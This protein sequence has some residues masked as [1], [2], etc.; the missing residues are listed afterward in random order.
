MQA[1]DSER[2]VPNRYS[3]HGGSLWVVDAV[4]GCILA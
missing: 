4:D 3:G 2:A 1:G